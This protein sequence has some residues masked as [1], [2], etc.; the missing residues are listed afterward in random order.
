MKGQMQFDNSGAV[1]EE[2]DCRPQKA[3]RPLMSDPCYYCLCNSCINN[4]ESRTIT[5]DELPYDWKP[6]FFC[7]ICNNFDGESPENMEREECEKYMIDDYHA[8]KNREKLRI[9]R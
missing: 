6:C 9:V 2:P 3:E 7:D 4:A 5:P 8:R 1:S